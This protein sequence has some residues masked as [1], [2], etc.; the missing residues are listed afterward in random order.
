MSADL[1]SRKLWTTSEWYRRRTDSFL[2]AMG[3][4][5][6]TGDKHVDDNLDKYIKGLGYWVT[7]NCEWSFRG[8][9]FFGS[10]CLTVQREGIV[11]LLSRERKNNR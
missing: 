9:R 8:K 1:E 11:R 6:K 7:A 2:R 4:L 3:E 5:P 10:N